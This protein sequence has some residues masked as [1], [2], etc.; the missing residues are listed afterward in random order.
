MRRE[1]KIGDRIYLTGGDGTYPGTVVCVNHYYAT[2]PFQY[3]VRFDNKPGKPWIG[4]Y[5][6]NQLVWVA[7]GVQRMLD[8]L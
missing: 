4:T 7:N 1:F 6:E 2:Y 8:V 3:D 5:T